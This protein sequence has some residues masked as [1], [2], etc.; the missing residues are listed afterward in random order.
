MKED[1]LHQL[2]KISKSA[3][4][5]FVNLKDNRDKDTNI[6]K[7]NPTVLSASKL[8]MFRNRL[9]ELKKAGLIKK[10][11]AN[12]FIINPNYVKCIKEYTWEGIK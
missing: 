11:K 4:I 12:I 5:L 3:F 7:V 10:V 1:I 8:K 6:C 9:R 2:I